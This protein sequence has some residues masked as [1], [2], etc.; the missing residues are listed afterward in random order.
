MRPTASSTGGARTDSHPASH[1]RSN[2]RPTDADSAFHRGGRGPVLPNAHRSVRSTSPTRLG[3]VTWIESLPSIAAPLE[4]V[5]VSSRCPP[6]PSTSRKSDRSSRNTRASVEPFASACPARRIAVR[7]GRFSS[8]F[9]VV[10]S[11][12]FRQLETAQSQ[13]YVLRG[14]RGGV[15]TFQADGSQ[16]EVD[17]TPYD[18]ANSSQ[19]R[20]WRTIRFS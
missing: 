12:S 10:T 15:H 11:A 2:P 3:S 17:R 19:G 1:W 6:E 9:A 7:I 18:G 4:Q 20:E 13:T 5:S 8:G 14:R 16:P